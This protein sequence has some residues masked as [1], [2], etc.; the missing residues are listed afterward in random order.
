M[1]Y[2]S[3]I[4]RS[5]PI[6]IGFIITGF[7]MKLYCKKT[8]TGVGTDNYKCILSFGSGMKKFC[9]V[10]MYDNKKPDEMYIDRVENND[11]CLI[12][13]KLTN[14]K[15]GM[16]K[17]IKIA[18]FTIKTLFPKITKLSLHDDSQIY[19]DETNKMFKLS[20]SYDYIIKY[21]Q[22][23]YQKNFN[24]IL[25][26]FLSKEYIKNKEYPIILSEPNTLMDNYT[27]SLLI[28]D[29]PLIDYSLITNIFYQISEYKDIYE[30]SSCPRDFINKLRTNLGN[31]F[32][33]KIDK[34][35]NQYMLFL[36]IK[37]SPEYWFIRSS[38][39]E[40]IPNFTINIL[41]NNTARKVFSGGKTQKNSKYVKK[42]YTIIQDSN[43][44]ESFLGSYN[45][46]E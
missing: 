45:D 24:A 6:V 43:F 29:E 17:L 20:L 16:V 30:S 44:T 19:C 2:I 3:L 27:K 1:N 38:N 28:L 40:S 13:G 5:K 23:W 21:N 41:R 10:A 22:S 7:N 42:G 32:C 12:E 36:K 14:F 31:D 11:L 25:P 46:Y 34:W 9:L 26:G 4:E 33:F 37:L 35:L 15:K 39:I 18:L 8:E